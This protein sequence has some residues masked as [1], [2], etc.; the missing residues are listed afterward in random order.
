MKLSPIVVG[1]FLFALSGSKKSVSPP[2][3]S[4]SLRVP[5]NAPHFTLEELRAFAA[6]VGFADPNLAAAIA[7]A[8]SY[9]HAE[10]TNIV[11]AKAGVRAERSFGLWQIN[12]L[13]HPQFDETQLLDPQ[14]NAQAALNLSNGGQ[15]WKL[16]GAFTNGGYKRYMPPTIAAAAPPAQLEAPQAEPSTSAPVAR[17]SE[18]ADKPSPDETDEVAPLEVE[19]LDQVEGLDQVAD[20]VDARVRVSD[21]APRTG[22]ARRA[23]RG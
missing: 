5:K 9:G 10:A 14:Y 3:P 7:M 23:R 4:P 2:A 22:R 11:N 8:E 20:G 18:P 13:A 6:Q 21:T 1:L 15:D 12:T 16:W 19:V 17:E